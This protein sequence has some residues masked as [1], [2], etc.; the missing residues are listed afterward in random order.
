MCLAIPG[1]ILTLEVDPSGLAVGN[2][3]GL[4]AGLYHHRPATHEL[5]REL[6]QD[7]RADLAEA[8]LAQ[9]WIKDAAIVLAIA[10]VPARTV[11]KYG[12]HG[13][14]HIHLEAGHAA[15]NVA[16]QAVALHLASAPVA[17][18]DELKLARLLHLKHGE[19]PL[20]LLPVGRK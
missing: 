15:Q 7:L 4:P 11:G 6:A 1:K 10:A 3:E 2:V 16:L 5:V 19:E 18:F 9:H 13:A 17:S 14:R 20:Y 12:P 8:S